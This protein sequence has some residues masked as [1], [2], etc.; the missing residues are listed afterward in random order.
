MKAL[1]K[2][3]TVPV[4]VALCVAVLWGLCAVTVAMSYPTASQSTSTSRLAEFSRNAFVLIRSLQEERA[5]AA[6]TLA[7]NQDNA[8]ARQ[9]KTWSDITD[10]NRTV[11]RKSIGRF[12]GDDY[13]PGLTSA[14]RQADGLLDGLGDMR[15]RISESTVSPDEAIAYYTQVISTLSEP[16]FLL[17]SQP[18]DDVALHQSRSAYL[19]IVRAIEL[20]SR[21]MAEGAVFLDERN[22]GRRPDGTWRQAS[23]DESALLAEYGSL[24]SAEQRALFDVWS[25][26]EARSAADTMR[27]ALAEAPDLTTGGETLTVA[28]WLNAFQANL[29]ALYPMAWAQ[30]QVFTEDLKDDASRAA[31][32]FVALT[33]LAG[34]ATIV[35]IA[36]FHPACFRHALLGSLLLCNLALIVWAFAVGPDWLVKES[37]PIESLQ[38][39]ALAAAFF[40]FCA[41]VVSA[42]DA[43]RIVAIIFCCACFMSFFRE[44]DFR[45]YGAPEWLIAMSSGPVRRALYVTIIAVLVVYVATQYRYFTAMVLPFLKWDAWPLVLW[46]PLLLVGELVE[47]ATHATRKDASQGYWANGQFWEELLELNAYLVLLFGAYVFGEVFGLRTKQDSVSRL[48]SCRNALAAKK[49]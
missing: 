32:L 16:I 23:P 11:F 36:W 34:L 47:L 31:Y 22:R 6:G 13:G 21:D 17:D 49:P 7:M 2:V 45:V 19:A 48:T 12:N 5:T 26:S 1:K 3:A 15:T 24:A 30:Q 8:S 38:A 9:F 14:L 37:G 40:I 28:Q 41:N 46:V 44:F 35:A 42:K 33:V 27:A 25:Q 43:S 39:F 4:A 18:L 10:R 20:A 29:A